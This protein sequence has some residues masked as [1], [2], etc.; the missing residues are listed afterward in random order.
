M[1]FICTNGP[2]NIFHGIN[3]VDTI[4]MLNTTK[5]H[6]AVTNTDGG[7]IIIFCLSSVNPM[8]FYICAKFHKKP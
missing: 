3:I 5:G 7:T 6:N 1:L 2:E 4:S 8:L